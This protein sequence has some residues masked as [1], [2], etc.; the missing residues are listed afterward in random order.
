[1]VKKFICPICG[2]VHVSFGSLIAGLTMNAGVGLAMLWKYNR[3]KKQ[4]L[5]ICIF[6]FAVSVTCGYAIQLIGI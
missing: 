2:Y 3:N 5:L 6:I 4:N 1:M